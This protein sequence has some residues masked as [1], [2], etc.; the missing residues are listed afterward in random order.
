MK[1]MISIINTSLPKLFKYFSNFSPFMLETTQYKEPL[2]I[3]LKYN[4]K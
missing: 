2:I 4:L 1:Q 3:S